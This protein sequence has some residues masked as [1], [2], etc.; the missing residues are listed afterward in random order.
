M[1]HALDGLEK[2][3]V[4]LKLTKSL[5]PRRGGRPRHSTTPAGRG[6]AARPLLF[7]G[8]TGGLG[9]GSLT[10]GARGRRSH[11]RR[12]HTRPGPWPDPGT[13]GRS[14][15]EDALL[16]NRSEETGVGAGISLSLAWSKSKA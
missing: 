14:G 7:P 6:R 1:A 16:S 9:R 5:N 13:A 11:L 10:R 4:S 3:P 15:T 2:D 8:L 12:R